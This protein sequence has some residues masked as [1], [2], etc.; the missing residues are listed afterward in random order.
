[1]KLIIIDETKLSDI[2]NGTKEEFDKYRQLSQERNPHKDMIRN[3]KE[4]GRANDWNDG[5]NAGYDKG[6]QSLLSQAIP[7]EKLDELGDQWAFAVWTKG[8]Q[9]SL[10]LYLQEQY[11]GLS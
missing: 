5:F 8:Y 7:I 11:G 1:M 3:G 4:Y 2:G 10:P 6:Q 9:R